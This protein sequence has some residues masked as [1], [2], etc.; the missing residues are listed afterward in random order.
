[1]FGVSHAPE[2][3]LLLIVG[4]IFL[5]PKRIPDVA[6]GLGRGLRNFRNETHAM[7]AEATAIKDEVLSVPDALATAPRTPVHVEQDAKTL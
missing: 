1:M 7:R 6:Q 2:L 3:I 5:G 4:L